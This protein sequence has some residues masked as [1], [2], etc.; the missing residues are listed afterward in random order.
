MELRAMIKR[1]FGWT[2]VK[3]QVIGQGT[4][5]IEEDRNTKSRSG[6]T[7]LPR[8]QTGYDSH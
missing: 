6:E 3:V 2:G 5:M 1:K 8:Y 4:W 7:L